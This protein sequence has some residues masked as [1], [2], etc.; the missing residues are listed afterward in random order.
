MTEI[1][2]VSHAIVALA[3][4]LAGGAWLFGSPPEAK[5]NMSANVVSALDCPKAIPSTQLA[6]EPA[7]TAISLNEELGKMK[8]VEL[9]RLYR[10]AESS[11]LKRNLDSYAPWTIF[12]D[13]NQDDTE[14]QDSLD[15]SLRETRATAQ[16]W[17]GTATISGLEHVVDLTVFLELT[18]EQEANPAARYPWQVNMVCSSFHEQFAIDGK[19]TSR[20]SHGFGGCGP[21][22]RKH[23]DG[24]FLAGF[25][26]GDESV[27]PLIS[28]TLIPMPFSQSEPA[29][30]FSSQAEQWK[31]IPGFRW[32]P[33]SKDEAEA[34]E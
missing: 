1:R 27:A 4:G 11:W 13:S 16:W 2:T 10:D 29:E 32:A 15:R 34:G 19:P 25:T 5:L 26:F 14:L 30:Y 17:K 21:N 33:S 3:F 31:T 8:F 12:R 20:G 6:R 23:G 28:L 24:Y 7:A 22:L 9:E 18:Q